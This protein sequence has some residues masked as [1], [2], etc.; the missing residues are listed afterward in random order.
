MCILASAF[1]EKSLFF[2]FLY[3]TINFKPV[4]K[5]NLF[6]KQKHR[7]HGYQG[8]KVGEEINRINKEFD[9]SIYILLYIKWK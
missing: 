3:D 6:T 5:M 7:K 1:L 4:I 9:I 2:V 8:G